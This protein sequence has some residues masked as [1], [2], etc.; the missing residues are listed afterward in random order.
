MSLHS[1]LQKWL[2]NDTNSTSNLSSLPKITQPKIDEYEKKILNAQ[3]HLLM[4][5]K[6]ALEYIKIHHPRLILNA[7]RYHDGTSF[8]AN[9][10]KYFERMLS[11]HLPYVLQNTLTLTHHLLKKDFKRSYSF[12][13]VNTIFPNSDPLAYSV[14]SILS[15]NLYLNTLQSL[16]IE[17]Q[18]DLEQKNASTV[19]MTLLELST[20][21]D[22]QLPFDQKNIQPLQTLFHWYAIYFFLNKEPLTN[23]YLRL[24]KHQ[25]LLKHPI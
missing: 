5:P 3:E 16:K 21:I 1:L 8:S 15:E 25:R 17:I 14:C 11:E 19:Q 18:K 22:A 4:A 13:D 12:Q 24:H 6:K 23:A 7:C 2:K 10:Q 20:F 9:T